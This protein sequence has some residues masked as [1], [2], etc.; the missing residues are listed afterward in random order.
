MIADPYKVLGISPTATD[1][2]LKKAYRDLSKQWHPDQNPNNAAYAEEKFKEVQEA[3]RQIVDARE[4]G[5]S[6][7]GSAGGYGQSYGSAG[8]YG[9]SYG[10]ARQP[11]DESR[12][13][14]YQQQ[15]GYADF[16]GYGAFGDFFNLWQRY[17]DQRR[18][19]ET[20][21]ESNEER[22]ARNYIN[23]GYYQEALNALNGVAEA[24]R[25][26]RWYYYAGMAS[27]G[28]G[29]NVRAMQYA[30]QATDLE[31]DNQTYATFLQR[32]R[33]GETF[34]AQQNRSYGFGMG[35]QSSSL[36]LSLCMANALCMLC[37]GRWMFCL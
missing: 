7:Y 16:R 15:R 3:Y 1:A 24:S 17:S 11:Y 30:Q 29:D 21:G 13:G 22:A 23:N 27:Q 36:C 28:V 25:G 5:T 12:D 33:N 32:L 37:G 10:S 8:G 34:Y 14:D 19:E 26:A 6:P 31:P 20:A 9:Q 4:K 2:E 35:N 18:A